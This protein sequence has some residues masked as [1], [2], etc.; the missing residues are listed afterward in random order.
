MT[1]TTCPRCWS[2]FYTA[3]PRS[4]VTCPFCG[5]TFKIGEPVR[6]RENRVA[7]QKDCELVI[8]N[9]RVAAVTTDISRKGLGVRLTGAVPFQRYD[10]LHVTVKEHEIDSDALVVWVKRLDKNTHRAGLRFF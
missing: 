7:L 9:E 10:T 4:C 2:G 8:K 1:S 6:R 3:F 5:F